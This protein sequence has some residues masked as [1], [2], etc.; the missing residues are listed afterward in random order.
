MR[1]TARQL[2]LIG[3]STGGSEGAGTRRWALDSSTFNG[4]GEAISPILSE[5]NRSKMTALRDFL[6]RRAGGLSRMGCA[7]Y[8]TLVVAV[9]SIDVFCPLLWPSLAGERRRAKTVRI[10]DRVAASGFR[11]VGLRV[12]GRVP[13]RLGCARWTPTGRQREEGR[14]SGDGSSPGKPVRKSTY[15]PK[16]PKDCWHR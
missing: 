4:S 7:W 2:Q 15:D 1:G 12:D 16:G 6:Y 13:F 8:W 11:M 10:P 14:W 5:L 9:T 3:N